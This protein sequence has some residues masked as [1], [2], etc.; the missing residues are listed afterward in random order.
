MNRNGVA[1]MTVLSAF[2]LIGLLFA[3]N[4]E[5]NYCKRLTAQY[6]AACATDMD[7]LQA[8]YQADMEQYKADMA[9]YKSDSSAYQKEVQAVTEKTA[10]YDAA[11]AER[12]SAYEKRTWNIIPLSA[13]GQT[14]REKWWRRL[15]GI[16]SGA[17]LRLT[18]MYLGSQTGTTM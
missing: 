1:A 8:Q 12:K 17:G 2:I 14:R 15:N 18:W 4:A 16:F 11:F 9:Q 5:K 7:R 3:G 13:N 6:E 10:E